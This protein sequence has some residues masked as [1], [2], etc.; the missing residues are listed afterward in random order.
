MNLKEKTIIIPKQ[1]THGEELI[2]ITRNEYEQLKK[3]FLELSDAIAKIQKGEKEL[4]TGKTKIT[5]HSLN[6][7]ERK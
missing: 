5:H 2:V 3:H 6:E 4:R 7:I 1:L